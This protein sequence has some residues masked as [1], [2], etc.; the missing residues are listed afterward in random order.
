V[1]YDGDTVVGGGTITAAG[2]GGE[3]APASRRAD[4]LYP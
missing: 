1:F 3:A 2:T 4:A